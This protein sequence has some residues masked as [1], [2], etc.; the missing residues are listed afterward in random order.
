MTLDL[1]SFA[2]QVRVT[3][4]AWGTELQSLGLPAGA[5]PELWNV[6]RPSAVEQVAR[7]YVKAGSDII[8]TNTFGANRFV[9]SRHDAG[10]RASELAE[11]GTAISR[12][13][14]GRRAKVFASIGPTGKIVM[15]GEVAR[16]EICSAFAE[17]AGAVTRRGADAIVLETFNE[18]D[19][20]LL[21]LTGVKQ[22]SPLPVVVSMTFA[23]GPDGTST[24]MGNCPADLAAA[25]EAG[26]ADA[27]GANCG[28][29]PADY[30]KVARLFREATDLPIW[31]KPNAGLPQAGP[32]GKTIFPMGPE[33]FV[34]FA[35]P[36]AAAGA[37]FIGG[38]CGTTPEHIRALR[39]AVNEINSD[40]DR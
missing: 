26:G 35:G 4:G 17:A 14:A 37:K 7:S 9:L 15:M 3:D 32:G 16:D 8:L 30:V 33:E 18:L 39:A 11:A 20:A 28:T 38:C 1:R 23:S 34:S 24:M 13:A 31:I 2:S 22:A 36:L 12:A 21:A 6:E 19:E 25:A 5:A 10:D 40:G 29:G 27:V